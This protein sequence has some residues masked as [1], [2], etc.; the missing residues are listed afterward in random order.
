MRIVSRTGGVVVCTLSLHAEGPWFKSWQVVHMELEYGRDS[1]FGGAYE[2]QNEWIILTLIR[3]V[4][5]FCLVSL[6]VKQK[7]TNQTHESIK[8]A[9]KSILLLLA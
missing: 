3:A 5:G 2:T 8:C 6:D 7:Y 1:T 9:K 4:A